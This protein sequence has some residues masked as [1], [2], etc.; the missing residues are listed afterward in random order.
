M[1]MLLI[2]EK[3]QVTMEMQ[4]NYADRFTKGKDAISQRCK[5]AY[6]SVKTIHGNKSTYGRVVAGQ[7]EG[8]AKG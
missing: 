1:K 6:E 4:K 2:T 5:L 3:Y 7:R 8:S